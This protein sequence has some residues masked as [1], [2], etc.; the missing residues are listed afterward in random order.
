M[1]LSTAKLF[2]KL[3]N[4]PKKNIKLSNKPKLSSTE[5]SINNKSKNKNK[6]V[7]FNTISHNGNPFIKSQINQL[8]KR[9]TLSS[10][11]QPTYKAFFKKVNNDK[12][13]DNNINNSLLN[14][15][16]SSCEKINNVEIKNVNR[17]QKDLELFYELF[18]KSNIKST[19]IIDSY[20]NNNLDKEQKK[21]INDYF[22]KKDKN[23]LN[24]MKINSFPIQKNESNNILFTERSPLTPLIRTNLYKK[25]IKFSQSDNNLKENLNGFKNINDNKIILLEECISD[26]KQFEDV[27]EIKDENKKEIIEGDNDSII[28]NRRNK[29]I[30]SSF[31]DSVLNDDYYTNLFGKIY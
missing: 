1:I 23:S 8:K 27:S 6:N 31:I 5:V 4:N 10:K 2:R 3:K 20:G 17:S 26:N 7:T 12:I 13:Q 9:K 30:D 24:K 29:S 18:M 15:E 28:E 22:N 19:I 11:I 16:P 14:N 21:L 25:K